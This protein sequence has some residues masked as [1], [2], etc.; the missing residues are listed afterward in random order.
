M[1]LRWRSEHPGLSKTPVEPFQ[2]THIDLLDAIWHI[3]RLSLFHQEKSHSAT[4]PV[5]DV[6]FGRQPCAMLELSE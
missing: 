1:N 5:V 6:V 2:K 3:H 4:E